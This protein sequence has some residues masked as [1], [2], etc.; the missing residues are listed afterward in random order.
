MS[1]NFWSNESGVG[2]TSASRLGMSVWGDFTTLSSMDDTPNAAMKSLSEP[3]I[4]AR[5]WDELRVKPQWQENWVSMIYTIPQGK[6][7]A[8][9][10][11]D[12][13]L[14]EVGE[15]EAILVFTSNRP[16]SDILLAV[17]AGTDS[18]LYRLLEVQLRKEQQQYQADAGPLL[19]LTETNYGH[20]GRIYAKYLATHD[21]EIETLLHSTAA[22]IG[23][24]LGARREE[25]FYVTAIATIIVGAKIATQLGLFNFDTAGMYRHLAAAFVRSRG[26]VENRTLVA[27]EGGYDLEQV[28]AD[29]YY[30]TADM[31]LRTKTFATRGGNG[32]TEVLARPRTEIAMVQY[33]ESPTTLRALRAHLTE[34]LGKR[35]LPGTVVIE[36][37]RKDLGATIWRQVLGGGTTYAGPKTWVVDIPL[38][39]AMI[40]LM[41]DA[42]DDED[43]GEAAKAKAQRPAASAPLKGNE[44]AL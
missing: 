35:N 34:W 6:E 40:E 27:T 31:R 2:K 11:S 1:I 24:K 13:T 39:A 17:T 29:Y 41:D 30:E 10:M 8:R 36:Q 38:T 22:K 32:K 9:M 5:F 15:W 44:A 7:R 28:L 12:T 3:R 25:R 43:E 16:Y 37:F 18:G 23:E 19:K 21:A 33:C 26:T 14:R 42:E 20:A 4:L